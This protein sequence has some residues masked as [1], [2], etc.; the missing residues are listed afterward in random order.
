MLDS[1]SE[2]VKTVKDRDEVEISER[3]Y[4]QML[5]CL[6]PVDMGSNYF[7]FQ[8]GDGDRILFEKK[9][10]SHFATMLGGVILNRDFSIGIRF[11]REHLKSGF[12]IVH[13]FRTDYDSG[14]VD[15][16]LHTDKCFQCVSEM[17]D[18]INDAI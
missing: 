5:E 8:E 12:K 9:C 15:P 13:I 3:L 17:A 6:P 4:F 1:I 16:G 11:S 14:I 18:F 2:L 10:G 7:I